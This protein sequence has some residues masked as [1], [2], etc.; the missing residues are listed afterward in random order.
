MKTEPAAERTVTLNFGATRRQFSYPEEG[1]IAEHLQRILKGEEYPLLP[2]EI[3][4]PRLVLDIGANVGATTLLFA[5]AYPQAQVRA[6]EPSPANY[7]FLARNAADLPNVAL[8]PFG[9]FDRAQTRKL[10]H[11]L[12]HTMESSIYRSADTTR[13][14]FETVDLRRAAE[15][16][17]DL[18]QGPSVVMKLDTEGCEV[19]ILRDLGP[20]LAN[21]DVLYV[22]Y[23]SEADRRA[24][25]ALLG[26][27]FVLATARASRPHLGE[28][29]YLSRRLGARIPQ[30]ARP[31]IGGDA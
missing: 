11:G 16:L 29:Q 31:P 9:L 2:P 7:A 25:D 20:A 12:N 15:E 19:P 4:S 28:L 17:A 18:G 27:N 6:Y 8:R 5:F 23:H 14:S 3:L 24:F 30:L 1:N 21:L 13:A 26:E 22:E 10:Y